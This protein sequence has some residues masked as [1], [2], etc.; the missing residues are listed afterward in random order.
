MF[1]IGNMYA[2]GYGVPQD[3]SEAV[4][5]FRK[6]AEMGNVDATRWLRN[7]AAKGDTDD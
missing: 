4:S 6:A 2:N 7:A 5:W 3:R 1:A